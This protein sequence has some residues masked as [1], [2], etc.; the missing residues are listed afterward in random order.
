MKFQKGRLHLCVGSGRPSGSKPALFQLPRPPLF[1]ICCKCCNGLNG[2]ACHSSSA[3]AHA[4]FSKNLRTFCP[5]PPSLHAARCTI[6][7]N[8]SDIFVI[9]H[10]FVCLFVC[11]SPCLSHSMTVCVCVCVCVSNCAKYLHVAH[12][13]RGL[14]TAEVSN[15]HK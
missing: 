3:P 4:T 12:A 15:E 14:R 2:F 10:L 9:K 5:L 1:A 6:C 11:L 13:E 7:I 8:H